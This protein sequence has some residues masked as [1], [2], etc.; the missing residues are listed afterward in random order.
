MI[1]RVEGDVASSLAPAKVGLQEMA[2]SWGYQLRE[3]PAQTPETGAL[4]RENEKTAD[5]VALVSMIL[6]IPSTALAV[7]DLAD[8]IHKRRRAKDLIDKA[9]HIIIDGRTITIQ[10]VTQN[11]PCDLSTL[12]PD[13]LLEL[14][15]SEDPLT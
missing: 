13:Q 15:E 12:D 1:I 11:G 8:R 5:P 7:A 6:A 4:V 9:K 10:L 14:S 2:D 3:I